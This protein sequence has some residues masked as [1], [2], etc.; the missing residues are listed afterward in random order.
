MPGDASVV[1][2]Q[3]H[4]ASGACEAQ[5]TPREGDSIGILEQRIMARAAKFW[6]MY[7]CIAVI[8]VLAVAYIRFA[9]DYSPGAGL[10]A[11]P[12]K[13]MDVWTFLR[14]ADW[15]MV[16][17][18]LAVV[19]TLVALFIASI[20]A[21]RQETDGGWTLLARQISKSIIFRIRWYVH[22]YQGLGFDHRRRP[23][24]AEVRSGSGFWTH[25]LRAPEQRTSNGNGIDA[26]D[27]WA[28]RP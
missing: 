10:A 11:Y 8:L 24:I 3:A 4:V 2:S 17:V 26:G 28:E 13:V 9:K 25:H 14:E 1:G 18:L 20:L 6:F 15:S 21:G 5:L 22:G 12:S 23:V 19:G 27:G 7:F 16:S